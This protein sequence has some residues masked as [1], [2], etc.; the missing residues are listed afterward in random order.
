MPTIYRLKCDACGK[1]PEV[2]KALAG[3]VATDGR[4]N[5]HIL[6][7]GYLAVRL[8]DGR[9][10]PLPHPIESSVLQ[11]L[12]FTWPE[13]KRKG[14]LFRITFKVCQKCGT[15]HEEPQHS[16]PQAG[17]LASVVSVPIAV[18]ILKFGV[19][20][21]WVDSFFGA[22]AAMFVVAGIAALVNRWRWSK[23]N[24][25]L[26]LK[27]CSNCRMSDFTTIAKMDGKTII[28][29]HCKKCSLQCNRAGMS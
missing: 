14:R 23:Q 16:D 3:W 18:I 20:L 11:D 7:D 6:P 21:N 1:A 27:D 22:F 15:V 5:G 13:A 9:F 19:Q 8:D 2:K 24:S 4:E 12:G 10:E 17:C 25:E 29:P 28:C 26:R